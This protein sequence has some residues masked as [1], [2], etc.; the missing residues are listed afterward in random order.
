MKKVTTNVT[1][2]VSDGLYCNLKEERHKNF[3]VD[4]RCRFCT[5]VGKRTFV[6]VMHNV[7]LVVEDGCLIHKAPQC[8]EN[9]FRKGLQVTE[10]DLQPVDPKE[11]MKWTL[12]EF[13][14]VYSGLIKAGYPHELAHK[15]A[16]ANVLNEGGK[17]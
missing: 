6:C 4:Q 15:A 1:Y 11:L 3:P 17:D 5:D 14:R 12:T 8:R 16:M 13:N 10:P 9:M 7:P 2:R